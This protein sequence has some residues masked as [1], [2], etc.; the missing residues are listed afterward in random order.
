MFR[1]CRLREDE[2]EEGAGAAA[3]ASPLPVGSLM[4]A[5]S[6]SLVRWGSFT[7]PSRLPLLG[8]ANQQGRPERRRRRR[9]ACARAFCLGADGSGVLGCPPLQGGGLRVFFCRRLPSPHYAWSCWTGASFVMWVE[10]LCIA[11]S[12]RGVETMARPFP[13]IPKRFVHIVTFFTQRLF[14]HFLALRKGK[15][16][17]FAFPPP[18]LG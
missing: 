15:P 14:I 12:R 5:G 6:A 3:P 13:S 2:R 17:F 1:R 11:D 18:R 16:L 4:G 9:G 7:L 10:M 8:A